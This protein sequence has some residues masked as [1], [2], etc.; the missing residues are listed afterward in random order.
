MTAIGADP[1][2]C[3]YVGDS[4][5]D[6]ATASAANIPFALVGWGYGLVEARIVA[7]SAPLFLSMT[8]LVSHI[9][10]QQS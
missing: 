5:V 2:T 8:D 1:A 4:A 10:P 6:V 7:P 3:L 9:L